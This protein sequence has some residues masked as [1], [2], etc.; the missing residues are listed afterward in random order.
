MVWVDHNLQKK[1]SLRIYSED[2][3]FVPCSW[4]ISSFVHQATKFPMFQYTFFSKRIYFYQNIQPSPEKQYSYKKECIYHMPQSSP[5]YSK[6]WYFIEVQDGTDQQ[7]R[8]VKCKSKGKKKQ[9]M[10]MI[11]T[12][13]N[14]N[15]QWMKLIIYKLIEEIQT[16]DLLI[17]S[18]ILLFEHHALTLAPQQLLYTTEPL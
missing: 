17:T 5:T 13:P 9:S 7:E 6:L 8:N 4:W 12:L 11:V 16:F 1:S 2:F 18:F 15:L 3:F 10:K 14:P